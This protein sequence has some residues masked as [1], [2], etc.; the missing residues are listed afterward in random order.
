M[1][2]LTKVSDAD[3][4]VS[5][6]TGAKMTTDGTVR[7]GMPRPAKVWGRASGFLAAA[8]LVVLAGCD[9]LDPT[10]V[11]NPRT[12]ADDLA[13]AAQELL[14]SYQ[15]DYDAWLEGTPKNT[16]SLIDNLGAALDKYKYSQEEA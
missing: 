5:P 12:T 6:S 7:N 13:E 8:G 1:A 16:E 14:K 3:V 11:E 4:L 15:E 2:T 10:G 9:F